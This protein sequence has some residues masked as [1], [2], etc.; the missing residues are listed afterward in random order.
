[1]A[2][3][4]DLYPA[5][6]KSGENCTQDASL[7]RGEFAF[8]LREMEFFC[9]FLRNLATP[10]ENSGDLADLGACQLPDIP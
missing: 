7:P 9:R 10:V 3:G 1:M 8:F 4:Q 2:V 5:P 6:K